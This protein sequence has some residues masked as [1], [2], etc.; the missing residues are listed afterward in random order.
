MENFI[1]TLDALFIQLGLDNS[2]S[3]IGNFI[4][5]NQPIPANTKLHQADFWTSSQS[6]FLQEAKEL[7][8]DWSEIVDQLDVLLR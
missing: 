4:D 2:P 1:H 7:D 3:F 8:A 6:S 5:T